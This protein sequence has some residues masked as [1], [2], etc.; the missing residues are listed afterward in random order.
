MAVSYPPTGSSGAPK[1]WIPWLFGA[2]TARPPEAEPRAGF[3]QRLQNTQ[4]C[5]I[6]RRRDCGTLPR[7]LDGLGM[8]G[9]DSFGLAFDDLVRHIPPTGSSGAPKA[10]SPWLFG[11]GTTSSRSDSAAT[12]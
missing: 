8:T 3:A 5:S 10:N 7:S 12:E 6:L 9:G 2:G 1:A 11:A 4:I